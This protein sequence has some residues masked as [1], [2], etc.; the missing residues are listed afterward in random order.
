MRA[1]A[2]ERKKKI[3]PSPPRKFDIRR[4]PSIS[5]EG[6]LPPVP[7][8]VSLSLSLMQIVKHHVVCSLRRWIAAHRR[9]PRRENKQTKKKTVNY[10]SNG[11]ETF[12]L[13]RS[14]NPHSD[15]DKV[16]MTSR[17]RQKRR[18]NNEEEEEER[19]P[20]GNRN[21]ISDLAHARGDLDGR[22]R[23]NREKWTRAA[24]KAREREREREKGGEPV[25][26]AR[27]CRDCGNSRTTQQT[28][29]VP[30]EERGNSV[31]RVALHIIV[32]DGAYE[33][34]EQ[35][36][37]SLCLVHFPDDSNAIWRMSPEG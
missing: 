24:S 15:W 10:S 6:L 33:M 22:N 20:G 32:D 18:D 5:P 1:H 8:S 30:T 14:E 23:R 34:A 28:H 13:F 3:T 19:I 4:D 26:I 29:A 35:S 27:G 25:I 9:G 36:S 16:T 37:L 31:T 21:P 17:V 7:P 12:L 11:T 2:L